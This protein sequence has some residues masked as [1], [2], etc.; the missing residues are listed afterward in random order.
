MY[1]NPQIMP[2]T[3]KPEDTLTPR[4]FQ[5]TQAL[6]GSKGESDAQIARL[7]GS[8]LDCVK[9]LFKNARIK[10]GTTNRTGLAFWF[11]AKYPTSEARKEGYF[12]ACVLRCEND[13]IGASKRARLPVSK[14]IQKTGDNARF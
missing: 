9:R 8:S 2:T 4:E 10:T 12:Q 5:A 1:I 13:V 7:M 3:P 14:R 11:Q 6:V